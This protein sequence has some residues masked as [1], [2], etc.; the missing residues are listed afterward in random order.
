MNAAKSNNL[1]EGREAV[2]TRHR[3]TVARMSILSA[4]LLLPAA[5]QGPELPEGVTHER[6]A[7]GEALYSEQGC[8]TC[9]GRDAKG[10]PG[11]TGDLT[12]GVWNFCEGGTFETLVAVIEEGLTPDRTGGIPMPAAAAKDL[13]GEEVEALAAYMWSLSNAGG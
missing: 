6:I 13:S 3:G 11:L 5:G 8:A 7:M 4:V 9:H 1:R 2:S 12:D 10:V